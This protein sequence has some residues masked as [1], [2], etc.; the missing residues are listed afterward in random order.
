MKA[1]KISNKGKMRKNNEDNFLFEPNGCGLGFENLF[2]VCDGVGGNNAGEVASKIASKTLK[3]ESKKSDIF[4]LFVGDDFKGVFQELYRRANE[5]INFRAH[6]KTKYSKMCTTMV[7][8][9]IKNDKAYIANVGDS[10]IYLITEKLCDDSIQRTIDS[11]TN[12]NVSEIEFEDLPK[13]GQD[14]NEKPRRYTRRVLTKAVGYQPNIQ[15]DYYEVDLKSKIENGKKVS[16]LMC[17]DGLYDMVGKQDILDIVT[18]SKLK[19]NA[20]LKELVKKANDNGGRDNITA[21]LIEL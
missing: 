8:C 12:D 15:A 7:T 4:S 1:Y 18:N 10:R 13:P 14:P 21:I 19:G 16:L 5:E 9:S 20:K 2:A 17:S 3:N 6:E 11:I